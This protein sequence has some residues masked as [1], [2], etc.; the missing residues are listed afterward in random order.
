MDGLG[1][2]RYLNLVDYP[3]KAPLS[4]WRLHHVDGCLVFYARRQIG[5]FELEAFCLGVVGCLGGY[6]TRG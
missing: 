2:M 5:F 3:K 1:G 4:D 6:A